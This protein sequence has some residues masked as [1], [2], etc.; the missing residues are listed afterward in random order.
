MEYLEITFKKEIMKATGKMK[1]IYL[2]G[3][4]LIPALFPLSGAAGDQ[5][6]PGST[7]ASI[8]LLKAKSLWFGSGNGAGMTLD[9]MAGFNNLLFG[10][11]LA[12]GDFK[13]KSDGSDERN[14]A[15]S[16]EG[17]LNLGGGYVWGR[18]SYNNTKQTGTLF[19]T[20]MLEPERGMPF[21]TVDA[22]VSDWLKQDY[23]L[24]MKAST[25][26][27]G[28]KIVLGIQAKYNT[29][30]GAKQVDPRSE[31]DYYTLNVKPGAVLKLNDHAVGMNF[32]YERINQE[33]STTNSNNQ[34]NQ[35]VY[36]LKGLGNFYTAVVGGLQSLG[37]FVY[38]GN[39]LGGAIQYAFEGQSMHLLLNGGYTFGVEDVTSTPTKP[40]KEGS[41]R[42][43]LY[44][45][46]L[47]V[48]FPGDNLH[49]AELSWTNRQNSGIEYV[50][51][52]DNTFEVQRWIT[53]YKSI[54]ST[55]DLND[56][57]FRYDFFRGNGFEYKWKTGISVDYRNSEDAYII[58]ASE[59]N[60]EELFFGVDA[61]V[62]LNLKKAGKIL[63]GADLG[64]KANLNGN[65]QYGGADPDSPV[66][67]GF[68]RPDFLYIQTDYMKIGGEL[69]W[70]TGIGKTRQ[71]GMFV[72]AALSC[73]LPGEGDDNRM[74]TGFGIGFT[75]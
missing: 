54:R 16:T 70:F 25:R 42:K 46:N 27:F 68:M 58:P 41:I 9:K 49:K 74:L 67:T 7:P 51:V 56:L 43:N 57:N 10:Y 33:S 13:R 23:N 18:F 34:A 64:Y 62:N 71:G 26:P 2:A 14:I 47:Q 63:A 24:S 5:Q 12:S 20:T 31:V 32:V 21:Y 39:A 15:V 28:D 53:T 3:M 11:D 66:I 35:D 55:F 8:E 69:S 19:N 36:V 72:K 30:T 48:I 38:D 65:Y 73:F 17:G 40:K 45:A 37:K 29:K 44:E 59:M 4:I 50:Q 60:L 52:L 61:K 75:F 22:N 6:A 1:T